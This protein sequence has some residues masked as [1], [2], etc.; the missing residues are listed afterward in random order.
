MFGKKHRRRR[1]LQRHSGDPD[2]ANR[3]FARLGILVL[4]GAAAYFI[5][6]VTHS[7]NTP[8]IGATSSALTSAT[9]FPPENVS[10]SNPAPR[11]STL[12]QLKIAAASNPEDPNRWFELAAIHRN[13]K[14]YPEAKSAYRMALRLMPDD[15]FLN[16]SYRMFLIES[17]EEEV[18][19]ARIQDFQNK[20]EEVGADWQ[21]VQAAMAGQTGNRSEAGRIWQEAVS[22]LPPELVKALLEDPV[23]AGFR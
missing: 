18:L 13:E 9:S 23:L 5:Y 2:R 17:G 20:G 4:L 19:T 3:F 14:R 1:G 21:I 12:D 8:E 10:T 22:T 15:F 16:V 11:V 6:D 7:K